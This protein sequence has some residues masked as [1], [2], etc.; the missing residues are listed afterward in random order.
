[1]ACWRGRVG[2]GV[3]ALCLVG[4]FG[5][6]YT[7]RSALAPH[8]KTV[9]VHP[10]S[11]RIEFTELTT[12]EQ[13]FQ[14]YRHGLEVTLG[15][16]VV[17]QY[18]FNGLLQ[19]AAESSADTRLEGDLVGFRRDALRYSSSTEV[20]EWRL[21]LVATLRFYDQRTNA[22][23]WRDRLVGDTTYFARGSKAESEESALERAVEDLARRIVERTVEHW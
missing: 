11:N 13:R 5:C 23:L 14:S 12:T 7:S 2:G 3:L 8:L 20:E 9:F 22:L 17:T 16:A 18:R 1:M 15:N 21:S 6:G 4:L 19:P 10:F